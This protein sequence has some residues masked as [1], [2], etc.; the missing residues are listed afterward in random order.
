MKIYEVEFEGICSVGSCLI[1]KAKSKKSAEKIA[2]QTITHTNE[3]IV[4]NVSMEK[5]GVVEYLSGDY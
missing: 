2:K 4:K 3:F 1:I 5:E